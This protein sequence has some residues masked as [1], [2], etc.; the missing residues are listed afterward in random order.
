MNSKGA[1]QTAWMRRYVQAGLR[2]CCS[3]TPK[4]GFLASRPIMV[5]VMRKPDFVACEK[6]KCRQACP[7]HL[8]FTSS[9]IY[10]L[11]W[12]LFK[13]SIYQPRYYLFV[14]LL[15][16]QVNSYGHGGTVSSPNHTVFLGK[17][18]QA[19][20]QYFVHILL[21]VTDN[22]PSRMIQRKGGE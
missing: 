1:D 17:L 8:L 20:N 14:L 6:Q 13:I 21:L 12:L 7:V 3:L 16:V 9:K 18:E 22:N 10:Y 11:N 5:F 4:T 15:Y 19:V 2:L